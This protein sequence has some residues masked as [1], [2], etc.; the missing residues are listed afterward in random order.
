MTMVLLFMTNFYPHLT[1][2]AKD[3]LTI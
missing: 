2:L 3:M 1:Q